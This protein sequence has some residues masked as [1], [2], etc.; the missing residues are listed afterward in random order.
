MSN[1]ETKEGI[2]GKCR[3]MKTEQRF[4]TWQGKEQQCYLALRQETGID[5]GNRPVPDVSGLTVRYVIPS[6]DVGKKACASAGA[7]AAET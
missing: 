6:S 4:R 5:G 7:R 1:C 2:C 3:S